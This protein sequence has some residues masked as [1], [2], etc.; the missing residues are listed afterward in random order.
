MGRRLLSLAW[1]LALLLV[2]VPVGASAGEGLHR[3]VPGA[4]ALR[5]GA[6][7]SSAG[8]QCTHRGVDIPAEPGETVLAAA[9]G[10]VTFAGQVP[11][12]GGGRTTAV[13]ITTKD[14]LLVCV[15]PLERSSVQKGDP[16]T[17]GARVGVVAGA[18]DFSSDNPHVHLSVRRAGSY[19]DP[20]PLL[21]ETEAATEPL[22]VSGGSGAVAPG[23][24]AESSSPRATVRPGMEAEAASGQPASTATRID[25]TLTPAQVAVI[26]EAFS[27]QIGRMRSGHGWLRTTGFAEPTL[28]DLARAAMPRSAAIVPVGSAG[29]G[30]LGVA[31][32]GGALVRKLRPEPEMAR[33]VCRE[34]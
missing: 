16:V 15:M 30:L 1:V 22:S 33:A 10:V 26:R 29:I 13:T 5:F 12:D 14:G 8:K 23:G 27:A 28:A 4:V 32:L 3:P 18:G 7:F 25:S 21:G 24:R 2:L 6:T 34:L 17:A 31:M 19:I 9:D 11:A 20:E